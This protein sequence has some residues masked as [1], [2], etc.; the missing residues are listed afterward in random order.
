ME[1][2]MAINQG[3]NGNFNYNNIEK[4]GKNFMYANLKRSNCYNCEFSKSNFDYVSFRGAHFKS[5]DFF[6]CSFKWAEFIGTNLK[7]SDFKSAVFE[8]AIFESVNLDGTNFKDAKFENTIFLSTDVSKAKNLN[9]KNP[10]I[11]IYNEMPQIEIS[12]ELKIAA[13]NAMNNKFVKDARVLDTKDGTLNLLNIMILLE[14]FD[15]ETLIKGLNII[16]VQLDRSF[17]TLSY[18]IKFMQNC[19]ANG[20]L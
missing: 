17:Y 20:T 18:L 13:Q 10:G 12:E 19:K 11:R 2:Q 14:N 4:I 7:G 15:E 3:V 8:N 6:Q 16:Q 1:V 5:C 9:I